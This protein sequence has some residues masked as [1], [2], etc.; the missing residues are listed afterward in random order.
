MYQRAGAGVERFYRRRN[1]GLPWT[2][3]LCAQPLLVPRWAIH[4]LRRRFRRQYDSSM[5][6]CYRPGILYP[7]P[8]IPQFRRK[9][10]ARR[11]THRVREFRWNRTGLGCNQWA[12]DHGLSWTRWPCL[13]GSMVARWEVHRFWRSRYDGERVGY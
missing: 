2:Y 9:L 13:R 1:R 10:V 11:F 5:E 4:R 3:P 12:Y 7:Q 6:C 8:T